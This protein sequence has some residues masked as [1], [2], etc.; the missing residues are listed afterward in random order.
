M[1]IYISEGNRRMKIPTFS[2]ISRHTCPNATDLCKRYCYAKKA[3]IYHNPFISRLD[4]TFSSIK[5]TFIEDIIKVISKKNC[6][7][8]RIHESGDFYSQQYLEKW[9]EICKRFPNITFLCY[10]QMY[11]LNWNG[12]PSN[13]IRYWSIWP[14]SKGVPKEGLKAYVIDNGK[15]KIPSIQLPEAIHHCHKGKTLTCENCLYCF[16]GNGN[17]AFKIH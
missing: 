12:I 1:G 6:K 10:T 17:V 2:L 3:E 9:F 11:N 4:N 14:D 8:L 16:N 15:G 13:L 5:N 7:Y